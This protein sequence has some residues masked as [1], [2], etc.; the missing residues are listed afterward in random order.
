[1]ADV[2][3]GED[4]GRP[5]L[6]VDG[7]VQSVLADDPSGYW[8]LMMSDV[9][10]RRALLLGLGAG[11]IARL[12]SQRF[13]DI[14]MVGIEEDADVIGLAQELLR[15]LNGLEIVQADA[16]AYIPTLPSAANA[17]TTPPSTCIGATNSC[18]A[19]WA[20]RSYAASAASSNRAAWS[21]STCSTSA[22]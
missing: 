3:L 16:F 6:L 21:C 10:P 20:G 12:L 1:V 13:G 18:T 7:T 5:V 15:D 11:T 4:D 22:A 19:S 9:R 14:P 2:R 17:L 8:S